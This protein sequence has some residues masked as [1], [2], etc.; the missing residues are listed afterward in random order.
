MFKQCKTHCLFMPGPQTLVRVKWIPLSSF[1]CCN[2]LVIEIQ[3][4]NNQK[5]S[6][7]RFVLTVNLNWIKKQ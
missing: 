5:T 1:Q 7:D 4:T 2:S 6:F 3:K